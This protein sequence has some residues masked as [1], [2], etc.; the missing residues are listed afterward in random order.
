MYYSI[1]MSESFSSVE[2]LLMHS[3]AIYRKTPTRRQVLGCIACRW[4]ETEQ[5]E[6]TPKTYAYE[7]QRCTG[8]KA[9]T[10]TKALQ[11]LERAGMV[12]SSY[13][14]VER[15]EG[16]G[17]PARRYYQPSPTELGAQF[18]QRLEPPTDCPFTP[19]AS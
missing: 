2:G 11:L 12:V 17:R 14:D 15:F 8:L 10:V 3:E 4:R 9:P 7:I 19:R 16:T 5:V 1:T 6:G 18:Q 13:E